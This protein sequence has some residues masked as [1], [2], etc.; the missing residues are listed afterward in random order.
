MIEGT[1]LHFP[2]Q[3]SIEENFIMQQEDNL[4]FISLGFGQ[5][6]FEIHGVFVSIF[7]KHHPYTF[8]TNAYLLYHE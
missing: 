8:N 3:I 6:Y 7:Y 4:D 1:Y 2:F 5:P